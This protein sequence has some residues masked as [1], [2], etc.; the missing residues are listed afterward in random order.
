[1]LSFGPFFLLSVL[2]T[3]VPN[4]RY[5]FHSLLRVRFMFVLCFWAPLVKN[6][7]RVIPHHTLSVRHSCVSTHCYPHL[8]RR[9]A[10]KNPDKS[11]NLFVH[12]LFLFAAP[13]HRLPSYTHVASPLPLPRT[14][15]L[16]SFLPGV[17]ECSS[18][19]CLVSREHVHTRTLSYMDLSL[20]PGLSAWLRRRPSSPSYPPPLYI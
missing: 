18:R 14:S 1:M 15:R 8:S 16:S 2:P 19:R 5:R 4:H 6:R 12:T 3:T 11:H 7:K 17:F 10:L 20:L 13:T 9:F